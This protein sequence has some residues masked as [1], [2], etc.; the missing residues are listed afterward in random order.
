MGVRPTVMVHINDP[1]NMM[2]LVNEMKTLGSEQNIASFL[3]DVSAS[4]SSLLIPLSLTF[5]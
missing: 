3:V 5:E 2:N 1:S 4:W